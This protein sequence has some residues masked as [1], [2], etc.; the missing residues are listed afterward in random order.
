MVLS[1]SSIAQ[2]LRCFAEAK[3]L[4]E[5]VYCTYETYP[6]NYTVRYASMTKCIKHC[7]FISYIRVNSTNDTSFAFNIYSRYYAC[8]QPDTGYLQHFTALRTRRD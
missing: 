6:Q 7:E 1:K 4:I 5:V 2:S 3:R 8:R